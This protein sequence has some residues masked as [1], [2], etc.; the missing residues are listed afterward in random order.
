[1]AKNRSTLGPLTRKLLEQVMHEAEVE[2]ISGGSVTWSIVSL[3]D[4]EDPE[5]E[6]QLHE[7]GRVVNEVLIGPAFASRLYN[8]NSFERQS[9][10]GRRPAAFPSGTVDDWV[11]VNPES[12][13][14]ELIHSYREAMK[15]LSRDRSGDTL[16]AY[17]FTC[18]H[19]LELQLKAIVMLGQR[20]HGLQAVLP[21]THGLIELWTWAFPY[22]NGKKDPSTLNRA[23]AMVELYHEL[24]DG[25]Y[26]FRYP[27]TKGNKK[28]PYDEALHQ[29]DL[30]AHASQI[31]DVCND[32]DAIVAALHL[33]SCLKNSSMSAAPR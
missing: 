32:L 27:V 26:A 25:S 4:P 13:W 23:R 19:S 18:R 21:G 11:G 3:G 20:L 30:C 17:M 1:M 9:T 10:T 5:L 6:L 31:E 28:W 16:F 22:M 33:M 2:K 8:A 12:D 15:L 24:D 7:A 29:F 14:Q